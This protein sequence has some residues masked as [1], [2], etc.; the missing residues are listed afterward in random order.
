VAEPPAQ[1]QHVGGGEG[2]DRL[3]G[4]TADHND[5]EMDCAMAYDGVMDTC[6]QLRSPRAART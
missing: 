2:R 5:V 6:L 3:A 4:T 1:D